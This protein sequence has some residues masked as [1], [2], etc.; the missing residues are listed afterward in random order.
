MCFMILIY[1]SQIG[2]H[3]LYCH[4]LLLNQ[5]HVIA[6]DYDILYIVIIDRLPE[7]L[8]INLH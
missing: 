2:F 4:C 7:L 3:S 5:L 1:I 8:Y 6:Y